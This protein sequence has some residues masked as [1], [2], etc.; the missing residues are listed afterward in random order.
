[1]KKEQRKTI[2][3]IHKASG[4]LA[5]V[6]IILFF[7]ASVYSELN[8]NHEIIIRVKTIILF[9]MPVMFVLMPIAAITGKKLAGK[10]SAPVIKSKN[11][12]VKFIAANGV[13]LTILAITLYLRATRNQIDETFLIIQFIEFGF[14][15][16]NMIL[17]GMMIRDGRTLTGKNK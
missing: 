13:F 12:R 10:S 3:T 14:G 7:L 6:V 5:L 16:F 4:I 8:G 17:L 11:N 2:S 9:S 15:L 1:M